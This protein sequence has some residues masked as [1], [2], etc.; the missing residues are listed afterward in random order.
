METKKLS[1]ELK[2]LKPKIVRILKK[3]KISK[4]GV[5]GSYARG[6]QNKK[7]DLDILIHPPRGIGFG[8][9]GIK[10][11]LEEKLKMKVDLLSYRGIHPLIKK[12]ILDDEV[13]II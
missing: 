7:S 10:I 11:E 8:F 3:N 13:R 2:M 6:D 5:F 12:S 4:A 1:P 9:V